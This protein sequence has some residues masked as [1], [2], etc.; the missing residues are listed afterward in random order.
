MTPLLKLASASLRENQATPASDEDRD[1]GD[2]RNATMNAATKA[3]V[4]GAWTQTQAAI[5]AKG[6]MQAAALRAML[7]NL[8]SEGGSV[9]EA[10]ALARRAAEP[11]PAA[12]AER[13]EVKPRRVFRLKRA[14][15]LDAPLNGQN[16][17]A[18]IASLWLD[19]GFHAAQRKLDRAAL[20]QW[21]AKRVAWSR[22]SGLRRQLVLAIA[23]REE[24]REARQTQ[25]EGAKAHRMF[26]WQ[27]EDD[28]A[29]IIQDTWREHRKVK[30][31]REQK[32]VAQQL[33]V[34]KQSAA[35]QTH[36]RAR[37]LRNARIAAAR[38]RT[39]MQRKTAA[40][41]HVDLKNEATTE[42]ALQQAKAQREAEVR[43]A[44]TRDLDLLQVSE[45]VEQGL[46]NLLEGLKASF[47]GAYPT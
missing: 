15:L 1:A 11:P 7:G 29:L 2:W 45:R 28:A 20:S 27:I 13:E 17:T 3:R 24:R 44:W 36:D 9:S 42:T 6:E 8:S 21:R 43:L 26:L 10:L 39:H 25:K 37:P 34:L 46:Q 14:A 33:K 5:D 4:C 12:I 38:K 40:I 47:P 32:Q 35:L 19:G 22:A 18:A 31:Q 16:T 41:T 30:E 23:D